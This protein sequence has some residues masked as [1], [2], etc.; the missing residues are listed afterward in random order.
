MFQTR[1][2]QKIK[3]QILCRVPIKKLCLLRNN[4]E[5]YGTVKRDTDENIIMRTGFSY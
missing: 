5:K 1:T 2:V 3:T 4:V